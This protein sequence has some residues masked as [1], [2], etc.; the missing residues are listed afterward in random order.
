MGSRAKRTG[1]T[2]VERPAVSPGMPGSNLFAVTRV[3]CSGFTLVELL[4]VIGIIAI[5]ISLLLPALGKAREQA[6]LCAR[7]QAFSRDQSMDPNAML[8]WNF[9][10]DRGGDNITNLAA[11]NQDDPSFNPGIL[12]GVIYWG[13]GNTNIQPLSTVNP[14]SLR[15]LWSNDG[16]FRGKPS[17]TFGGSSNPD[18]NVYPKNPV[19]CGKMAK[20]LRKSQAITIIMWVYC[21][22]SNWPQEGSSSLLF[23]G[24]GNPA[25]PNPRSVNIHLPDSSGTVCWDT[26]NASVG[27]GFDR[28]SMADTFTG[29]ASNW[30]LWAFTKNARAGTQKIYLNGELAAID[31]TAATGKFGPFQTDFAGVGTANCPFVL[32]VYP[33][34]GNWLGQI[35]ELAIF[36]ADLSP[37]ND[38]TVSGGSCT[39]VPGV[40]AVRFLQ[41][42]QMGSN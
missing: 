2:L 18:P 36:N 13:L 42:F 26:N 25:T 4:V 30:Q 9:Q 29:A 20:L 32:G 33:A 37:D 41:M 6:R 17:L 14:T 22:P 12:D 40:P 23:W 10:N 28:A 27:L 15:T 1:S 5:L 34:R 7:W 38:V 35:D 24:P 21:P 31:A 3:K 19:D 11:N 16:R 8:Y 39:Q